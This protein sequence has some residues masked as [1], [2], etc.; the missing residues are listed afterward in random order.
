MKS[1][2]REIGCYYDRMSLKFNMRLDSAA[3]EVPV[4]LQSDCQSQDPIRAALE[5][6][7]GPAVR[8]PLA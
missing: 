1:Q 2:S 7:R 5:M 3:V 6:S 4:K 8:I